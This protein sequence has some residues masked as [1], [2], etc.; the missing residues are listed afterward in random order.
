MCFLKMSTFFHTKSVAEANLAVGK[1]V[2][3]M[4]KR[5][6]ILKLRGRTR[7]PVVSRRLIT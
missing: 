6:E 3:E 2:R 5:E 4:E 7:I 1:L